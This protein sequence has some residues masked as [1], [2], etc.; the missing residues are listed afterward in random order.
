MEN[1]NKEIIELAKK[2]NSSKEIKN[3][4]HENGYDIDE[5]EA[6]SIYEYLNKKGELTEEELDNVS[7]GCNDSGDT[8]K[9]H[10]GQEV[11]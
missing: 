3:L 1:I 4:A 7:S 6:N 8:P 10:V 5:R 2:A 9:Y 11:T